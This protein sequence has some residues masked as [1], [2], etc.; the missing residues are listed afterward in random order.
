LES[1][2]IIFENL[3]PNKIGKN[4]K[5][6]KRIEQDIT[7]TYKAIFEIFDELQI[8]PPNS[9]EI[10]EAANRL[11][12]SL[13][14]NQI[15]VEEVVEKMKTYKTSQI[16]KESE[17][18][19]CLIHS[20]LDEYRF[21]HEYPEREL[22]IMATLFGQS[23][24]QKLLDG[25]IE[26]IALKYVIEGLKKG[27][28]N[29]YT[30]AVV[31]LEQFVDKL[32][33]WPQYLNS[34]VIIPALKVSTNIYDRVMEKYNELNNKN[35]IK[36]QPLSEGKGQFHPIVSPY[37]NFEPS[38][39]EDLK[40][41]NNLSK[42][43]KMPVINKNEFNVNFSRESSNNLPETTGTPNNPGSVGFSQY[44]PLKSNIVKCNFS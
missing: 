22:T 16:Q 3:T 18:Y 23:I 37:T 30:F 20:L 40:N 15:T 33:N 24:N 38:Y 44:I 17:I 39:G 6:S 36:E 28:G 8:Q 13:F 43:S 42:V 12:K 19:A 9:E 7:D 2:A 41:K 4:P 34:L 11:Y 25:I 21:F 1:L 27:S 14:Q 26:T 5:V 10:E 31:A 32:H 35:K 29:M